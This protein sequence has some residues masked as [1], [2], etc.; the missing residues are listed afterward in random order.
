[1]PPRSWPTLLFLLEEMQVFDTVPTAFAGEHFAVTYCYV[2]NHGRS[3]VFFFLSSFLYFTSYVCSCCVVNF[4][5]TPTRISHHRVMPMVVYFL[6]A[7][8]RFSIEKNVR[9]PY[10][11]LPF[12]RR[13]GNFS[14]EKEWQ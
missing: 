9:S 13:L 7:S 6:Q 2:M 1:M 8:K 10:L 12:A 14:F 11:Y 3:F 4:K 5:R